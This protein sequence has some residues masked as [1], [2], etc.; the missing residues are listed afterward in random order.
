[1][2]LAGSGPRDADGLTAFVD[3]ECLT[4][5]TAWKREIRDLAMVPDE[6]AER[7]APRNRRPDDLPC[8]IR[9]RRQ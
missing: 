3:G 8:S 2:V 6:S 9:L 7:T 4:P 1:V 5:D